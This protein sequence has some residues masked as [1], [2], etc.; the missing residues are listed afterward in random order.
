M[1][2]TDNI[3]TNIF[4]VSLYNYE[5]NLTGVFINKAK[6]ANLSVPIEFGFPVHD[7]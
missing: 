5:K 3:A 6:V 2:N 4:E 1:N 7:N